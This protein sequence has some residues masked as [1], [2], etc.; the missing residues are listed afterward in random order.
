M[1]NE[2][3]DMVKLVKEWEQILPHWAV[4]AAQ[5][6]ILDVGAQ[7][8]TRDGRRM[9]NAHIIGLKAGTLDYG[10]PYYRVL[11][12]AGTHM[13]M[14]SSEINECFWPPRWISDINEV[15]KKFDRNDQ[16]EPQ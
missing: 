14:N 9:G 1:V 6:G 8:C 16:P 2:V 10:R 3:N 12:D 13:V 4:R 11:T 15:I 7:L 5:P